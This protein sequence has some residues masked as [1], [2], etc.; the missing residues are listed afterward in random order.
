MSTR[1]QVLKLVDQIPPFLKDSKK[2]CCLNGT[3]VEKMVEIMDDPLRWTTFKE[4]L[5]K[6]TEVGRLVMI[7]SRK[8]EGDGF[9]V[10]QTFE[11]MEKLKDDLT[12]L[13]ETSKIAD[14]VL[15][16]LNKRLYDE[17][18]KYFD[19]YQLLHSVRIFNPFFVKANKNLIPDLLILGW[20]VM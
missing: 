3:N 11:L 8:I 4:E 10:L 20:N 12:V 6:V 9:V 17:G 16:N 14:E 7:T 18:T 13:A 19:S 1:E 2:R 15:K 5:P